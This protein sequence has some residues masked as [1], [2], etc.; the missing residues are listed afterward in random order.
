MHKDLIESNFVQL[1]AG[2]LNPQI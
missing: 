2:K 1:Q